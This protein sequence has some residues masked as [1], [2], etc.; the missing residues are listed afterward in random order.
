MTTLLERLVHGP[1]KAS[2]CPTYA[3]LTPANIGRDVKK[4]A[5]CG[6]LAVEG[7]P[8]S[9]YHTECSRKDGCKHFMQCPAVEV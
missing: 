5:V 2:Y 3:Q 9:A 7:L 1:Q 6:V 8:E 4:P